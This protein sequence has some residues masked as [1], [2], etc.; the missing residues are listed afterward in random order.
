MDADHAR[1]ARQCLDAAYDGTMD[2]PAILGALTAAGFEGYSVDYRRH[3]TTYYRP[4]GQSLD[5]PMSGS[6]GAVA[7]VFDTAALK[8][9]IHA[10]QTNAPGYSYAGFSTQAT[11]AGCAGYIVSIPGRRVLYLGRS[12]ETHVEH[13]PR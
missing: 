4:D 13:F 1:V 3:L 5:L 11:Q 9:A 2:F 12:A 7:E 6:H 10:A 8:A